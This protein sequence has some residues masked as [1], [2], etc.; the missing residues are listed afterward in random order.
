MATWGGKNHI[1]EPD[2]AIY[3]PNF[4]ELDF[5]IHPVHWT[6]NGTTN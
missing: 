2:L 1:S 5:R 6:N 4:Y 3:F